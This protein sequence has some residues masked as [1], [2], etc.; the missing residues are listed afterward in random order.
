MRTKLNK[1]V[2]IFF[3]I[4]VTSFLMLL[5]TSKAALGNI[6]YNGLLTFL[7]YFF[8]TLIAIY[9]LREKLGLRWVLVLIFVSLFLMQAY[10]FY[11]YFVGTVSFLPIQF[12]Y[13]LGILSAAAF[14]KFRSI[15]RFGPLILS[16][17]FVLYMLFSGWEYWIHMANFG[18]FTGRVDFALPTKFEGSDEKANLFTEEDF[19]GKVVLL[20]FWYTQCGVCFNK[21]PQVEAAYTR[22]K[23][24][25]SVAVFAVDKPIAEDKPGEA[26]RL[27][28]EEGYTFP[29]LVTIDE[30]MSE[31]WGVRG[32]PT[33]F[34][35]D[36]SG[37]IVYKGDIAG[38]VKRVDELRAN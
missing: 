25:P 34:V 19:R 6:G 35:I 2:G 23:E 16:M 15:Y 9:L 24:D 37:K 30:D 1:I 22:W 27:I 13:C 5:L 21:F 18:T 28:K 12:I 20:D 8:Y 11:L 10:S 14:Y 31:K 32:F 3:L 17:A 26:F 38:A 36:R 33:T 7:G 4:L 29:V